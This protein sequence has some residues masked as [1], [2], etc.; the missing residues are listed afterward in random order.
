MSMDR[1]SCWGASVSCHPDTAVP[2]QCQPDR[3][4]QISYDIWGD[5]KNVA[6]RLESNGV[7]GSG[8]VSDGVFKRLNG[9]FKER[10]E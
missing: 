6:S 3:H 7:P 10:G 5:S 8:P 4:R 1:A 2:G 9:R